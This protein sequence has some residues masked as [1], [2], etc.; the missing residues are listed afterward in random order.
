MWKD[1]R[2]K[3]IFKQIVH[4]QYKNYV[5]KITDSQN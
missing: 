3:S 2:I 4:L 1:G 5:F